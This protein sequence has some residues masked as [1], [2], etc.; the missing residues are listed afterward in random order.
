MKKRF[1]LGLVFSAVLLAIVLLPSLK[2][3]TPDRGELVANGP[4]TQVQAREVMLEKMRAEIARSGDQF[5]VG[6]NEAMQYSI[7]QLCTFNPDMLPE[8]VTMY[9]DNEMDLAAV[10]ALPTS[11]TGYYT[12][13][14]NQGSCGSC[15]SFSMIGNFEGV[16][17]KAT[18]TTV[19]LS[20]QN[21]LDCNPYGYSCSGGFFNYGYLMSPGA[22]LESCDPYVGYKKTCK[23]SCTKPYKVASW[24]YVGTSS[25]VPTTTAIKTAIYNYGTVGA[26][27][28]VDSYWQ[29]YSGGTFTRNATGSPNHAIILMGWDDSKGAWRLKNSWGTSWGESGFMWIKYGVQKVGYAANRCTKY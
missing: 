14:K 19:D 20:E 1:L 13:I 4:D 11:Y 28:Y 10:N 15:W 23:S 29:A 3:V 16:I 25:S 17:K 8:D 7:D 5:T 18:G 26:A 22:A 21:L 2:G 9:E 27:V 24:A 12:P 6:D